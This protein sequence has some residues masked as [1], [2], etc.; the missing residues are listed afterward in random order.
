MKLTGKHGLLSNPITAGIL[1]VIVMLFALA[2]AGAHNG[3][4]IG[5]VFLIAGI[6]MIKAGYKQHGIVTDKKTG[7]STYYIGAITVFDQLAE[8][9]GEFMTVDGI[10]IL[11]P[12]IWIDTIR[13]DMTKGQNTYKIPVVSKDNISGEVEVVSTQ[14]PSMERIFDFIKFGKG[15]IGPVER[16]FE[17]QVAQMTQQE[18]MNFTIKELTQ[19]GYMLAKRLEG[20]KQNRF[21]LDV[22]QIKVK[23][24]MPSSI[25]KGYDAVALAEIE[26]EKL[27]KMVG[28]SNA[29]VA[30]IIR[31]AEESG[32]TINHKQA[33]ER[34]NL[35]RQME[36]DLVTRYQFERIGPAGK[37]DQINIGQ[38]VVGQKP[39]QKGGQ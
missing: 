23:C 1:L 25:A 37:N 8:W 6:G 28:A 20:L 35:I 18:A 5:L 10:A 2:V 11:A 3:S 24:A 34:L 36:N 17:A 30:E 13:I 27:K 33:L 19:Q 12:W 29:A 26:A 31:E 21:G 7:E 16:E 32:E 15:K 22:V 39:A 4:W 9:N 14:G 38:F